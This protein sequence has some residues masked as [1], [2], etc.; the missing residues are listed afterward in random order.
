MTKTITLD[1]FL[2]A[3]FPDENEPV[4]IRF[5]KAK[6]EPLGNHNAARTVHTTRR[7][8]R[9][10]LSLQT[11][12]RDLNRTR[13]AYFV[14]NSGG[15]DDKSISRVNAFFVEC[16]ETTI[17]DQHAAYARAP[18]TPSIRLETRKSVHAY[19]LLAGECSVPEWID[20]QKRLIARFGGD[21]KNKNPS[22]VFRL[23]DFNHVHFDKE[24]GKYEY[25][26]VE[27]KHFYPTRRYTLAEM[28]AAF[29][30]P[31]TSHNQ[32]GNGNT[33]SGEPHA[34]H[35]DAT[36]QTFA[37]W[38]DLNA[39]LKTRIIAQAKMNGRGIFEMRGLC[40]DGQGATALMF[41]PA[42]GAIKCNNGC[43]HAAVLRAFGLPEKPILNPASPP[44]SAPDDFALSWGEL[45]TRGFEIPEFILHETARG[46]VAQLTSATNIGKTTLLLNL[47]LAL[48]CGR[49]FPPL[50]HDFG[51]PRKILFLDF[52][53]RLSRL[54]HDIARMT[55]SLDDTER[56]L[57][58]RNLFVVC[59]ASIDD[60]PLTLSNP[61]HL[62]LVELQAKEA[63]ADL[64]IIDTAAGAFNLHN[65][66]DNAEVT[67][68]LQK[69]LRALA[70]ATDATVIYSH[71]IGKAGE[72]G[73]ARDSRA[74]RGRGAS[75]YGCFA[76]SVFNLEPDTKDRDRVMLACAKS[77]GAAFDD[78]VM[79]L[80]RARR[81]FQVTDETPPR[82]RS[83]YEL[84][85]DAVKEA[86]KPVTRKEIE[87]ALDGKVA[88]ASIGRSLNEGTARGDLVKLKHGVYA[89][90][91]NAQMFTPI[92]DE[93]LNISPNAETEIYS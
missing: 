86:G 40:H 20:M 71:H 79:R 44:T 36:G 29:P 64:I 49:I 84:V 93:H 5:F 9:T 4:C 87:I 7:Q 48:A 82:I 72:A 42:T 6:D 83:N 1:D 90:A 92:R 27:V 45:E 50:V 52:E 41:N 78:V 33:G 39:E 74:Y 10:D 65:E 8:L 91:A 76:R 23:P 34:P 26:R 31:E 3:F 89:L 13:G 68:A 60:E 70:C 18:L 58:R 28:Q 21:E 51:I 88:K 63:K 62:K 54:K 75:A 38:D 67:R 25:K 2:A 69:P 14:V 11:R 37:T 55:E 30:L 15:D 35:T 46:E 57:V 77:K 81:C 12:L 59:D 53:T 47:S 32:A 80:D 43:T 56:E 61:S 17:A 22:R 66:N 16:D 24:T 19:Y 73:A 85:I